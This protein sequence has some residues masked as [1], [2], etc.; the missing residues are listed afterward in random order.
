[1]EADL[2]NQPTGAPPT[3]GN[4]RKD[5]GE[6][7][8]PGPWLI[9]ENTNHFPFVMGE[10]NNLIAML[11]DGKD[12]SLFYGRSLEE[13]KANSRLIASAP[14]MLK[15]VKRAHFWFS[16][17]ANYPEGTGGYKMAKE[18]EAILNSITGGK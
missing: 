11:I 7:V 3:P 14:D 17:E 2:W 10:D 13:T 18:R 4:E 8:T 15:I 12:G 6:G 16:N 9:E 5:S 1:M